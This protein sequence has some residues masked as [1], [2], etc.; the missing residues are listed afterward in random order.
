MPIHFEYGLCDV[1]AYRGCASCKLLCQ[2]REPY[3]EELAQ[4]QLMVSTVRRFEGSLLVS[5]DRL[6]RGPS[7]I[8]LQV[9]E[10]EGT[11]CPWP[12][13]TPYPKK[14]GIEDSSVA[15]AWIRDKL[16]ICDEK[17]DLCHEARFLEA[18]H[19]PTRVLEI[20]GPTQ[21][22]L[23]VN[24]GQSIKDRYACLSHCWGGIVP[25]QTTTSRVREFQD[26]GIPWDLL[27]LT[28]QHAIETTYRLGLKYIWI[29][30]F[31]IVQDDLD[32]WRH[33]GSKMAE[34]Y[35]GSYITLAATG[36]PNGTAGFYQSVRAN[37]G[38][39]DRIYTLHKTEH[40]P[41]QILV[42]EA[43]PVSPFEQESLPLQQRAW[44]F[45]E[46]LLSR[47]IVHFADD[48]LYW[49]CL[50]LDVSEASDRTHGGVEKLNRNV[51]GINIVG[52][53]VGDD[54]QLSGA[55]RRWHNIV[56]NYS[57]CKLTF[58]KDILPALQGVAAEMKPLR[59][60]AYFAGLWGDNLIFDL[61]WMAETKSVVQGDKYLAPSWSWAKSIGAVRWEPQGDE[62]HQ[63][64]QVVSVETIPVGLDPMGEVSAGHMKLEGKILYAVVKRVDDSTTCLI[65]IR[66]TRLPSDQPSEEW[67]PD[68]DPKGLDDQ[69]V[70][71]MWIGWS[72]LCFYCLVLTQRKDGL[73]ERVGCVNPYKFSG[74]DSFNNA[75]KTLLTIV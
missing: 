23:H 17:H 47:R 35:A 33:E 19:L 66:Q 18:Q 63:E 31:C 39:H 72:R 4:L 55:K 32:D 34:I 49:E 36:A 5:F 26:Q 68:Y 46:R 24:H 67:L 75:V 43:P 50:R 3:L 70:T 20:L 62:F 44:F 38:Y 51:Q 37:P 30:S 59:N 8:E 28:F 74:W 41:Y 1:A 6:K 57:K 52:V 40:D 65:P 14:L 9:Y 2:L 60:C 53:T 12:V 54:A 45:Q 10:V 29:D 48:S 73:Y 56:H 22:R 11:S 61:L 15:Q 64:A 25:L 71:V 27:P 7:S 69:E 58:D 42:R 16:N 13:V 21:V